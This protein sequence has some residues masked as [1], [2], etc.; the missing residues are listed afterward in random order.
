VETGK[1]VVDGSQLIALKMP[2]MAANRVFGTPVYEPTLYSDFAN[3]EGFYANKVTAGV[4]KTV[5]GIPGGIKEVGL[6]FYDTLQVLAGKTGLYE[7]NLVSNFSQGLVQAR[8]EGRAW[9]YFRESA[10]NTLSLGFW[11]RGKSLPGVIEA[12]Q[13]GDWDPFQEWLGGTGASIGM[14]ALPVGRPGGRP[15]VAVRLDRY[16]AADRAAAAAARTAAR[17]DRFVAADRA[18]AAAANAAELPATVSGLPATVSGLPATGSGISAAA[19]RLTGAEAVVP[20]PESAAAFLSELS[21]SPEFLARVAAWNPPRPPLRPYPPGM[22]PIHHVPNAMRPL[23]FGTPR[24]W[25]VDP[26][27]FAP[28][29]GLQYPPYPG[30]IPALVR[31]TALGR[32]ASE[33]IDRG[34]YYE[35]LDQS[36]RPIAQL[37]KR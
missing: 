12:A 11:E 26:E 17:L 32:F 9:E 19:S 16:V 33:I 25:I 30:G 2:T 13:Q 36:G 34:R 3:G 10:L 14:L 23:D 29:N 15:S 37:P 22:D 4:V 24:P 35:V 20:V 28:I 5:M 18:A 27:S 8:R 6:I 21:S 31:P 1:V 7:P